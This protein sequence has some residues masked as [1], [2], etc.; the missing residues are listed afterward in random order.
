MGAE[1]ASHVETFVYKRVGDL[2][3]RADV[4]RDR[5]WPERPVVVWI[6]GGALIMGNRAD[7]PAWLLQA[8]R[9]DRFVLVSLEYRLA[10]ETKLPAILEDVEDALTWL[11]TE[12][13]QLFGA[14]PDLIV[15]VGESAG[16]YLALTTGFRVLPRVTGI[17]SLWGYGDLT[18]EWYTKPSPHPCH[19]V[20]TP[21]AD[22]AYRQVAG[23]P[24]C[25]DRRRS[26][27]GWVF[28]QFCRQRGLWPTA[29]S[30]W[31]PEREEDRFRAVMPIAQVTTDHPPTLLVHGELDTDVPHDRSVLMSAE[32]AAHGVQHRLLS[33]PGAEHGLD[34]A[35]PKAVDGAIQET[36][37]FLRNHLR[38]P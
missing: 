23:A 37:T 13:P 34:G 12:G 24:L 28:Y 10:P 8:C 2:A 29:V 14:R 26:G 38:Q 27:D 33:I 11:R 7:V 18:G 36:V 9:N 1:Q 20:I 17:V 22:D 25:D 5:A 6:H 3:I 19:H 4:R 35:D 32:L 16:G 31:D 30:G 21:T 15:V